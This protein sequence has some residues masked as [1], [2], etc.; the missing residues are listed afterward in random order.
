MNLSGLFVGPLLKEFSYRKVAVI[1]SLLCA[2]GLALTASA[3]SVAHIL[4][5]YSVLNGKNYFSHQMSLEV[6][7]KNYYFVFS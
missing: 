5:T 4:L 7:F 2:L 6:L 3:T 1:G